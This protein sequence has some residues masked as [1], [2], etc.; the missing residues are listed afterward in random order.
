MLMGGNNQR[1]YT[2][3]M[4]W[5]CKQN[6]SEI[7][8]PMGFNWKHQNTGWKLITIQTYTSS[9]W[10]T[11]GVHTYSYENTGSSWLYSRSRSKS[12]I[13]AKCRYSGLKKIKKRCQMIKNSDYSQV[14]NFSEELLNSKQWTVKHYERE[15]S[16]EYTSVCFPTCKTAKQSSTLVIYSCFHWYRLRDCNRSPSWV[17]KHQKTCA[18]PD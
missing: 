6:N 18:L 11:A 12:G 2:K 4:S 15:H 13:G 5:K 3:L 7:H 16:M 1:F 17:Q 10:P 9:M 8:L 14:T